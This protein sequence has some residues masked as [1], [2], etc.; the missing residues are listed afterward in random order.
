MEKTHELFKIIFV[1]ELS[2]RIII[3]RINNKELN[4]ICAFI[5]NIIISEQEHYF[6]DTNH[7]IGLYF[8]VACKRVFFRTL[9]TLHFMVPPARK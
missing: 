4:R 1:C 2:T 8:L 5:F 3:V 9:N 7:Y 6:L